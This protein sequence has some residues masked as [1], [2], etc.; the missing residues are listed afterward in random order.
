MKFVLWTWDH[1]R[2]GDAR[3]EAYV[4]DNPPLRLIMESCGRQ[5]ETHWVLENIQDIHQILSGF[6][7]SIL[8][9]YIERT[10]ISPERLQVVNNIY[11]VF[12]SAFL[13]NE[14]VYVEQVYERDLISPN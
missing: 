6:Q 12:S 1:E 13:H 5:K 4:E 7:E 10:K 9:G 8:E 2:G 14:S 3:Y 11:K